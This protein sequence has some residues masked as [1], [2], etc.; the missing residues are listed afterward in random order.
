M[1]DINTKLLARKNGDIAIVEVQKI[2]E[3]YMILKYAMV[4]SK[5]KV[6]LA[7][8]GSKWDLF[9]NVEDATNWIKSGLEVISAGH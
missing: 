4:R 2:T 3:S 8:R 7:E 5:A 9:S 1:Q 6:F